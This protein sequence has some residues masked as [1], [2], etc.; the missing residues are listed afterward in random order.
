MNY[1]IGM[2]TLTDCIL[3]NGQIGGYWVQSIAIY[4]CATFVVNFVI[5]LEMKS[6]TWLHHLTVWG[7]IILWNVFV[8]GLCAAVDYP[9]YGA[10]WQLYSS[11]VFYFYML[12]TIAISLLP[13]YAFKL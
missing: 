9:L 6:W 7:S 5:A 1:Y 11:P 3:K 13:N 10:D 2:Y 4:T 12:V 8:I